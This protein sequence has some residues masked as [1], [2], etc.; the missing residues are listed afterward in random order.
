MWLCASE[1][2]NSVLQKSQYSFELFLRQKGGGGGQ[3]GG[4]NSSPFNWLLNICSPL[5]LKLIM[6]EQFSVY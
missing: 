3:R 4:D 6:L 1:L 2:S 5:T